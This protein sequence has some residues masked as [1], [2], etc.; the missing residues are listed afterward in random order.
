M[1][2]HQLVE[3]KRQINDSPD[4][5]KRTEHNR[6]DRASNNGADQAS[7]CHT[8]LSTRV[9]LLK[10]SNTERQTDRERGKEKKVKDRQGERISG[11]DIV[12]KAGAERVA[13]CNCNYSC[14]L[15]AILL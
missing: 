8:K 7:N 2:I 13:V 5:S 12:G 15:S 6:A 1:A 9:H 3:C 10:R 14:T 11:A 4:Q